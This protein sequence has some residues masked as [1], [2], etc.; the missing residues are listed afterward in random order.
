MNDTAIATTPDKQLPIKLGITNASLKKLEKE[1]SV[2]PDADTK[3]GYRA[4]VAAKRVLTPLRTGVE[5]ERK[6]QVAAAVDHQ[7]RVNSVANQIKERI[8]AIETPLYNAKK[9]VDEAEAKAKREAKEAEQ[10][11]IDIIEGKVGDIHALTEGLLNSTLAIL[12]ARKAV[13]DAIE[14]TESD[15]MEFIEPAT[16][17]L[18]Q[19]KSQLTNAVNTAKQLAEQQAEIDARQKALDDADRVRLQED[20]ERQKEIN[21]AAEKQR[22]ADAERQRQM[23]EQQ[24]AMDRKQRE[25]DEREAEAVRLE[26]ERKADIERQEAEKA[27]ET[28]LSIEQEEADKQRI[29]DDKKT[30]KELKKRLPE[31]RKLQDYVVELSAVTPPDL[32]DPMLCSILREIF[33]SLSDM[34]KTVFEKTQ[35]I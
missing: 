21:D 29:I 33:I 15:Y 23:N 24:E 7:R 10:A 18:N 5:A 27:E 14:I 34:K 6:V 1:Y 13:A 11:R 19:V 2:V 9:V 16:M 20:A 28:R 30:A 3:E 25:F 8:I 4:I 26:A 22:L 17:A 35:K 12:E 32:N 31:D